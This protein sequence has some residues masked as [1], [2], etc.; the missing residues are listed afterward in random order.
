MLVFRPAQQMIWLLVCPLSPMCGGGS[1]YL[2]SSKDDVMCLKY[3]LRVLG[4][5]M[6]EF[7]S[8]KVLIMT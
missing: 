7:R 2:P 6:G 1:L 5:H 8:S 4:R 3:V